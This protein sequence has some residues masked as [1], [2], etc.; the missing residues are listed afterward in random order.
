MRIPELVKEL[1]GINGHEG[2]SVCP[3]HIQQTIYVLDKKG[4]RKRIVCDAGIL[5]L[6]R[7]FNNQLKIYQKLIKYNKACSLEFWLC[8]WRWKNLLLT[9][10]GF[11]SA[12]P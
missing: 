7:D 12:S 10:L 11:S 8:G 2:D 4:K 1:K 5:P 3:S 9:Q 6:V